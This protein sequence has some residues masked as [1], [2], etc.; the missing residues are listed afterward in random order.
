VWDKAG[1]LS[2]AE[3]ER[4]R[5]HP[6][7][8]ERILSRPPRLA[9]IGAIAALHHERLDGSGY[10]RGLRGDALPFGA[11]LVAAADAFHA[12]GEDR[13]YRTRLDGGE[14]ATALR[15]EAKAGRLDPD[16]V[17]AVLRAAGHRVPRR[18]ALPAGVV[19]PGGRGA[20]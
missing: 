1:P 16:A 11:R 14:Q 13:P 17:D 3:R 10:P 20:G 6:Y 15:S 12:M 4:V 9:A 19:S 8:T 2:P 7:L 5:T 18:P